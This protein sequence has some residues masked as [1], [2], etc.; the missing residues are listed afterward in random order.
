MTNQA[1]PRYWMGT[2]PCNCDICTLTLRSVFV[3][4]ATRQGPWANMCMSCHR[5]YGHG[6][7]TGRGQQYE[8]QQDGRWLKTAG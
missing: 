3:D 1:K 2:A 7:G 5:I 6:L 8:K 4:G